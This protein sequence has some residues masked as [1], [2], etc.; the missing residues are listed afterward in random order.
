MR[1]TSRESSFIRH[2]VRIRVDGFKP[3][4]LLSQ[5]MERHIGLKQIHVQDE[6]RIF[7]TVAGDDLPLLKKLARSKYKITAVRNGGMVPAVLRIRQGKLRAVGIGIFLLFFVSQALFVREINV[8]GCKSITETEIRASLAEANL[9]E[10]ARK[11]FDCEAIEKKLF[12]EFDD[13]VWARVAYEGNYVEVRIAESKQAPKQMTDRK[14]ACNL[15]AERECYIET[16]EVYKGRKNVGANDFVRKGDILIAGTVPLEHP[17]FQP[18]KDEA[19][20]HYVHAEGKV[21]ARVPYYFSFSLEPGEGKEVAEQRLRS[22][23]KEK[24]PENAQILKKD[25]HFDRKKNIINVYGTVETR[26]RVGVEKEIVIDKHD[27]GTKKDTD[28]R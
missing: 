14:K 28:R 24:I 11:R 27:G 5:A 1:E 17:S 7:L 6:T 22:W 4:R 19:I 10:G 21:V 2:W 12:R 13:I 8:I 9:Y 25:F 23:I 20:E 15:V 16:I 18:A 3:E 26:Q